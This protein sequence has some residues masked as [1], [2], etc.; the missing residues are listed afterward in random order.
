LSVVFLQQSDPTLPFT[1]RDSYAQPPENKRLYCFFIRYDR[2]GLF[3]AFRPY[4]IVIVVK[5]TQ[6]IKRVFNIWIHYS[7]P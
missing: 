3:F 1:V 7:T 6:F 5:Y 2:C 4:R